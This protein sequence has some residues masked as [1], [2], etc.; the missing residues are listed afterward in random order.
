[1]ES[2]SWTFSLLVVAVAVVAMVAVAVVEEVFGTTLL[3][4]YLMGSK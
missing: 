3:W 1:M 2:T 4:P